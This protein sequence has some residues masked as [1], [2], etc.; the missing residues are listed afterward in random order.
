MY[1]DYTYILVIIGALISGIASWNVNKTFKNFSKFSNGKGFVAEDAAALIMHKVGIYD[2]R[3][4]HIRDG[5]GE[6]KYYFGDDDTDYNMGTCTSC[7]GKGYIMAV[8][9]GDSDG[10]KKVVCGSCTKYV[11]E[12]IIKEDAS[13]EQRTW[14]AECWEE[15]DRMM[16]R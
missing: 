13:G 10:G 3:I 12:L 9:I 15:Y 5:T 16:G 14:C 1:W 4:E 6:V 2:V 11:D 8:P 7:D